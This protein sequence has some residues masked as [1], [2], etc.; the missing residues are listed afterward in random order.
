MPCGK[1]PHNEGVIAQSCDSKGQL[2]VHAMNCDGSSR[3]LLA[4]NALECV[5]NVDSKTIAHMCPNGSFEMGMTTEIRKCAMSHLASAPAPATSCGRAPHD[6]GTLEYN[7]HGPD[8]HVSLKTC[9]G[10]RSGVPSSALECVA[11]DGTSNNPCPS[12]SGRH[13][14]TREQRFCVEDVARKAGGGANPG[15]DGSKRPINMFSPQKMDAGDPC[16]VM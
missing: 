5:P 16:V 2:L 14:L 7:C 15:S 1:A 12:R 3:Q 10:K 9:D 6:A 8:V 4:T 11:K 13:E